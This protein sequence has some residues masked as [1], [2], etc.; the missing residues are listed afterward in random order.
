MSGNGS[1]RALLAV[2]AVV[3][4]ILALLA[5]P[6]GAQVLSVI[7]TS[8][9]PGD[10]VE[11]LV[12]FNGTAHDPGGRLKDVQ[13]AIDGGPVLT[14]NIP[15]NQANATWET[16]WDSTTVPDGERKA[17]V[18]VADKGGETSAPVNVTFVVD[19]DK[20]PRL[21]S[22]QVLFDASGNGT[23]GLWNNTTLMPT[24]R[25]SFELTFS[26]EMDEASLENGAAFIGG[27][28]TWEL[29]QNGTASYWVNV[30][31]L[32]AN[33]SY[34]F[35]VGSPGADLAGNPVTAN[36]FEF[37]TVAELTPGTPEPPSDPGDPGDPGDPDEPGGG[38]TLPFS[39]Y[40]PWLW[41]GVAAAVAAVALVV[42]WRKGVFVR[43]EEPE[44]EYEWQTREGG[45]EEEPEVEYDWQT[46]EDDDNE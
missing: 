20:E 29:T 23:Y 16:S 25:L 45:S 15:G 24:T 32:E 30:S 37:R 46:R 26:E 36:G 28:S 18:T 42:A 39:I 33:T 5:A 6:A 40:S 17:M 7:V 22:L 35:T 44:V 27:A 10:I 19:N 41:A 3:P 38:L 13:L 34:N 1:L 12:A 11:G 31:Y 8:P 4:M 21:E 2:T 9:G 43:E 14:V